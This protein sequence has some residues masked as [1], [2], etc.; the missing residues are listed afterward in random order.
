MFNTTIRS[1]INKENVIDLEDSKLKELKRRFDNLN[2]NIKKAQKNQKNTIEVT[3]KNLEETIE[4][5]TDQ[6][7]N[8]EFENNSQALKQ[9][10]K[11]SNEKRNNFS[12]QIEKKL[13]NL[14]SEARVSTQETNCENQDI[15]R[16]FNKETENR[17]IN[18]TQIMK[19]NEKDYNERF[20]LENQKIEISLKR[21]NEDVERESLER[22]NNA[23]KIEET[24][25]LEIQKLEDEINIEKDIK[26]ETSLKMEELLENL[27]ID[28]EKKIDR[29]REEREQSNNSLLNLLED[30][31]NKIE[32]FFA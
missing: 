22:K 15:I 31:C 1:S 21:I 24:I 9:Q 12:S 5:L 11:D 13:K 2:T 18:F 20:L 30:S 29:E 14:E 32:T 26:N 19:K 6:T 3:I 28:L 8:I 16:E 23:E 25:F 7:A 10:I 27:R 4:N 17:L